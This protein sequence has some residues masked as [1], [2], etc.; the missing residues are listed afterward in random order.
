[1][2]HHTFVPWCN[3]SGQI[4]C[5]HPAQ[6]LTVRNDSRFRIFDPAFFVCC[7]VILN[8]NTAFFSISVC[9]LQNVAGRQASRLRIKTFCV[10]TPPGR[11]LPLKFSQSQNPSNRIMPAS[12]VFPLLLSSAKLTPEWSELLSSHTSSSYWLDFQHTLTSLATHALKSSS[13]SE[14]SDSSCSRFL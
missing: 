8:K 3:R 5:F 14:P 10:S 1:M 7:S 2:D 4:C 13:E 9:S 6:T 11:I 12:A